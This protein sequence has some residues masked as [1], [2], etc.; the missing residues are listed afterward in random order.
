[1]LE[2][3]NINQNN[4]DSNNIKTSIDAFCQNYQDSLA[5]KINILLNK[6]KTAQNII[7]DIRKKMIYSINRDN[8]IW[9]NQVL[10]KSQNP[11]VTFDA[12]MNK[13]SQKLHNT[14]SLTYIHPKIES[15]K[16]K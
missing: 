3:R 1:M 8:V 13:L 7:E 6:N 16:L 15:T 5:K 12:D 9:T 14:Q 2:C 10:I 4:R 11:C